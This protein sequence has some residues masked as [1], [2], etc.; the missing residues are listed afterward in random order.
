M[1]K[2]KKC[3]TCWCKKCGAGYT[4][5]S[6]KAPV[7]EWYKNIRWPF[8]PS[9]K[10]RPWWSIGFQTTI[11]LPMGALET[12]DTRAAKVSI[13]NSQIAICRKDFDD[14]GVEEQL[15]A[16]REGLAWEKHK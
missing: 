2:R 10:D 11:H 9:F 12:L 6:V 15:W 14:Y 7:S 8:H 1:T 3:K 4:T 5:I 16:M 13:R